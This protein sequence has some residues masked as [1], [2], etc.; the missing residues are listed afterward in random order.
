[1]I[2]NYVVKEWQKGNLNVGLPA[3]S[4]GH[5]VYLEGNSLLLNI[6]C[7][8]LSK[9]DKKRIAEMSKRDAQRKITERDQ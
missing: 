6:A 1:M 2:Y 5:Y 8:L 3:R 9:V 7:T 4:M